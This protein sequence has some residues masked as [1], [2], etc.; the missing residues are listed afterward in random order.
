MATKQLTA[1][2]RFNCYHMGTH[3]RPMFNGH[4]HAS[5][6][7]Q[8]LAQFKAICPTARTFYVVRASHDVRRLTDAHGFAWLVLD[9]S[10]GP[11]TV[12]PSRRFWISRPG[13]CDW[14]PVLAGVVGFYAS[15]LDE[16]RTTLAQR[17][18][19]QA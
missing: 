14:S 1:R 5:T 9:N 15:T 7:R 18:D 11:G 16:A 3:G 4:V 2:E 10:K 19:R 6:A 17:A 13:Y 12:P 8:A